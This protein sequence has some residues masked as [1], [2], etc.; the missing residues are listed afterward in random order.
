VYVLDVSV[1]LGRGCALDKKRPIVKENVLLSGYIWWKV[2]TQGDFLHP[3]E[4]P[5]LT[6]SPG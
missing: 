5:S 1:A 3:V 4:I 2:R 6:R